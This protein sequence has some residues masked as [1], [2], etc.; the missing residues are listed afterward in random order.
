MLTNKQ[1]KKY[2]Y[3]NKLNQ[4]ELYQELIDEKKGTLKY[5]M[6]KARIKK[7]KTKNQKQEYINNLQN[8]GV[9]LVDE[10]IKLIHYERVGKRKKKSSDNRFIE[11]D[12]INNDYISNKISNSIIMNTQNE[13]MVIPPYTGMDSGNY[14]PFH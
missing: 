4:N 7:I 6:L 3:I 11:E 2:S 5:K 1:K 8:E 9:K 12:T 14:A 10:L 13:N